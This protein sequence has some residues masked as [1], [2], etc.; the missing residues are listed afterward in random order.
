MMR[1]ATVGAVLAVLLVAC[2]GSST[3]TESDGSTTVA[4]Q[5]TTA[6]TT[7]ASAASATATSDLDATLDSF[8]GRF[9]QDVIARNQ[10]ALD[11]AQ[12]CA[13]VQAVL[14][15][16]DEWRDRQGDRAG[17]LVVASEVESAAAARL[18]ALG[19]S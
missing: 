19:C 9:D 1:Q 5:T 2:G 18:V 6:P 14:D 17:A 13:D 11:D 10:A 12:S 4:A 16:F 8:R 3:G 15:D 7:Q